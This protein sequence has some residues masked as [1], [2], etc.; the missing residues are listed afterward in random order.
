MKL[1]N[2]YIKNL[3]KYWN[4]IYVIL[5]FLPSL[6]HKFHGILLCV[7]QQLMVFLCFFPPNRVWPTPIYNFE[8]AWKMRKSKIQKHGHLANSITQH[9]C[10]TEPPGQK[11]HNSLLLYG[12]YISLAIWNRI[13][14]VE[15]HSPGAFWKKSIFGLFQDGG[16]FSDF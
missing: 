3:K 11:W 2:I 6:K 9:W 15:N 7:I 5:H 16:W 1:S 12:S 4:M 14:A 10:L 8:F 13:Q